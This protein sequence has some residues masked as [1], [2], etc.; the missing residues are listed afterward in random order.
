MESKKKKITSKKKISNEIIAPPPPQVP[1]QEL[2]MEPET[3]AESLLEVKEEAEEIVINM[4]QE[5][6]NEIMNNGTQETEMNLNENKETENSDMIQ[7]E[8]E[9]QQFQNLLENIHYL[10]TVIMGMNDR[11]QRM[12]TDIAYIRKN[13]IQEREEFTP[14]TINDIQFTDME[15]DNAL[16]QRNISGDIEMLKKYHNPRFMR[17]RDKK[18]EF[19][20][21]N[22]WISEDESP[23]KFENILNRLQKLYLIRNNNPLDDEINLKQDHIIRFMDNSYRKNLIKEFIQNCIHS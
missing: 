19:M 6:Y 23:I 12:E 22:G 9:P 2:E 5:V 11:I 16:R 17:V 21:T 10:K 14:M 7:I 3:S 8:L 13:S 15:V 1:E 4:N 18:F 20:S